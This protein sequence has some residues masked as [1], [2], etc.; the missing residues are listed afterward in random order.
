MVK[1]ASVLLIAI[2]LSSFTVIPGDLSQK[3]FGFN[4]AAS[5]RIN[6]Q[7]R[8]SKLETLGIR[9]HPGTK[10]RKDSRET[11]KTK[12]Q[13]NSLVYQT[14]KSLPEEH[15]AL[16]TDLT[17]F[18][19]NDGRR[20]LAGGS[21]IILRCLRVEEYELAGVLT[22]E[23]GHLVDESFL[24]GNR[25]SGKSGFYDFGTPIYEDDPSVR[26][27]RLSFQNTKNRSEDSS[28]FDFVTGYALTDP[29]EDFAETYVF[30][31]LHGP[32]F[33]SLA[34]RNDVLRDKYEFMKEEVFGG[35]EFDFSSTSAFSATQRV[36]DATLVPFDV[37]EFFEGTS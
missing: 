7:K 33:R 15:T 19:T 17:L 22:H 9:L 14:L 3:N 31:R 32:A 37:K 4:Y 21:Q 16:V 25:R 18:Y 35:E 13:C 5:K 10:H 1:F 2:T 30:Y 26:F 20:G 27:Y 12:A 6:S 8:P 28:R 29:F 36:Y 23:I 11:P 34:E 24:R